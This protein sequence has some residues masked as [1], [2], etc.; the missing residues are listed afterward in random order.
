[1]NLLAHLRKAM[2]Q[3][4]RAYLR[5][6][7]A[8]NRVLAAAASGD[9]CCPHPRAPFDLHFDGYRNRGWNYGGLESYEREYLDFAGDVLARLRPACV[10]DVG[11]N[12]GFWS[13]YLCGITPPIAEVIAYEPDATNRRLLKHNR[14]VNGL[15][16]LHI[17]EVAL[18]NERGRATFHCD[19][20]TGSTGSLEG[21]RAFTQRFYGTP[22]AQTQVEVPT[23]DDELADGRTVPEFVKV[24]I[25]GHEL[26]LLKGARQLLHDHRPVLLIEV[27][28]K[29][30]ADTV[31]LLHDAGY[32]LIDP[33]TRRRVDTSD[34]EVAAV[35]R[36]KVAM[37]GL[38]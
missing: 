12:V 6:S 29:S 38:E 10:W 14:D 7:R 25:E 4:A 30:T 19:V 33:R 17:R 31:A 37:L 18:S 20:L 36:E 21:E 8:V 15:R 22:T 24:D 16:Q 28:G 1:M 23:I 13:L 11:A 32:V 35:P 9:K 5:R 26:G 3:S 27:T 2:P 34:F